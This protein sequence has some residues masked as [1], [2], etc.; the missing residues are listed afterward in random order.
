MTPYA[1]TLAALH[2]FLAERGATLD[3]IRNPRGTPRHVRL[4]WEA[5]AF[6]K[7]RGWSTTQTGRLFDRYHSSVVYGLRMQRRLSA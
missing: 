4:R 2:A 1:R 5:Y 3:E 7:A 6:L